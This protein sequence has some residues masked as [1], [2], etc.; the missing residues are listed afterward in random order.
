MVWLFMLHLEIPMFLSKMIPSF[1]FFAALI[2]FFVT[3]TPLFESCTFDL[4][5]SCEMPLIG[6]EYYVMSGDSGLYLGKGKEGKWNTYQVVGY[7]RQAWGLKIKFCDKPVDTDC[8]ETLE[9]VV[10][11][12]YIR[13]HDLSRLVDSYYGS[14]VLSEYRDTGKLY[15]FRLKSIDNNRNHFGLDVNGAFVH[16]IRKKDYY[17]DSYFESD[18]KEGKEKRAPLCFIPV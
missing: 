11:H 8:R 15:T 12:N 18:G 13:T 2:P 7:D 1:A 10:G 9:P 14:L 3:S 5:M 17:G 16:E 6:K 4:G